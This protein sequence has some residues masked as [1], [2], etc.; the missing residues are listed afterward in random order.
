MDEKKDN[1]IIDKVYL[2]FTGEELGK[3]FVADGEAHLDYYRKSA[4][5]YHDFMDGNSGKTNRISIDKVRLPRQIEKDERFWTV[6]ATKTVFDD[7]GRNE[8][9]GGLLE[10]TYGRTAPVQGLST[11]AECL[12]G[13][14]QLYY[15]ACL[16]SPESY[17]KWLRNNLPDRQL[18][19]YVLEAANRGN[20][21]TLEGATH[22][23]ALFLNVSNGFSWLIEAKVLSDISCMI[24]F[25][26]FRNQIAR[27]IDVMLEREKSPL[28]DGLKKRDPD[29]SL[30]ALLTPAQFKENPHSRLYGWLMKEYRNNPDSLQRD[31][32]HRAGTDWPA[33]SKRLGWLTFE[34]MEAARPGSCPWLGNSH[35]HFE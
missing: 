12:D 14:M 5:R 34:D 27:N 29:R 2:P 33:V 22:V 3:H 16:P 21:R 31:L 11:W 8:I 28:G 35:S 17:V 7:P 13:E 20:K 32:I 19:P 4:K 30:F 9:L 1:E 18:I 25:D 24:S 6:T 23:D 15:E 26:N 10:K